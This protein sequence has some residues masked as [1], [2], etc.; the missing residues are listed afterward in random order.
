MGMDYAK[1]ELWAQNIV[2]LLKTKLVSEAICNPNVVPSGAADKLHI[3]GAGEVTVTAYDEDVDI[4]YQDP[5]DTDTE[6]TWNVDKYFGILVKDKDVKQ[7]AI[8]WEPLYADRGAYGLMK[9]L[10]A[11]VFADHA[12]AGLDSYESSTTAWQLGTA[13]AD[14]PALFSALHKQLDD[15]DAAQE[16]RFIVGPPSLRQA[17]NLFCMS[18][19]STFGD[20]VLANGFL[21]PFC[22]MNVYVSNN[23]TTVTTTI[24]GLCG[25]ER[26]N[27]ASKV[28]IDPS[29]IE[30][31]RAQG[32]FAQLIRGRMLGG[33][34]V[35][36]AASLIDVNLHT[37]LIA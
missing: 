26:E 20:K 11:S 24:H 2:A 5:S 6:F 3:V 22:G 1:Q 23:L 34:K 14:V 33:H 10:D 37:T 7:T 8:N 29:S 4:T 36:R 17:I 18:K 25:V 28:L 35:Y 15:V 21:G 27:V 30:S 32:R 12:S 19:N 13:G 9:A 16:G 31:L